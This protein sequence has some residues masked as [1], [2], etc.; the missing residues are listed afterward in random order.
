[1]PLDHGPAVMDRLALLEGDAKAM[2][3]LG[4]RLFGEPGGPMFPL[5]LLA[6]GAIKRNLSVSSAIALVVTNWNMVSARA[7][8]RVHIDTALRFSAAWLVDQPH[9]FASE[10]YAGVRIDKFKASDGRRLT[11][12]RLVE[13]RSIEYPWLPKVYDSL[14]GY[15]HFS[16]S[17]VFDAVSEVGSEDRTISFELSSTDQKFPEFSWIEIL[18][19]TR[20]ATGMLAKYLHGYATTKGLT[21]EQLVALREGGA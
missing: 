16:G 3:D 7:L 11:D 13:L 2:L 4:R 18:E 9:E 15:V 20:E 10:V 12:A 17:H 8:L 19:C 1:M 21:P 6:F 5:D 14:S